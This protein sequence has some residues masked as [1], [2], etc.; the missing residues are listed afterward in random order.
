[1]GWFELSLKE[2]IIIVNAIGRLV[3]SL[4][5]GNVGTSM[6]RVSVNKSMMKSSFPSQGLVWH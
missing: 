3:V 4:Y 6:K 2:V 1:M 5:Y